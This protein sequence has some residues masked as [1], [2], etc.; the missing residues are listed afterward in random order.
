MDQVILWLDI[1]LHV[2]V[3]G[4]FALVPGI[5][6]WMGALGIGLLV[7]SLRQHSPFHRSQIGSGS[8]L[9]CRLTRTG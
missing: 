5:V 4:F 9:A 1:I 6:I 3:A 8:T 7:Q 2:V